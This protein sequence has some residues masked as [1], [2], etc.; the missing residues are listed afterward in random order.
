MSMRAA[1]M[2]AA[3]M[4]AAGPAP[5]ARAADGPVDL[6][7]IEAI[8]IPAEPN[9][10][11]TRAAETLREELGR[12]Y[13]LKLRVVRAAPAKGAS[14]ILV[15]R[16]AVRAGLIPA[17]ALEPLKP[18]GFVVKARRGRIALAGADRQGN[19]YAAWTLLRRAGLRIYPWHYGPHA[20]RISVAEPLPAG[21]LPAFEIAEKPFYH[22]RD[23]AGHLDRGRWGMSRR[24]LVLGDPTQ[25]ANRDLFGRDRKS[26]YT[27]FKL[28]DSDYVGWCHTA[29]Y[30]VPRD[31]YYAA[32]PEYFAIHRQK[33]IGPQGFGRMAVCMTHPDVRRI[34]A[35]RAVQWMDIQSDRRFFLVNQ[36]DRALCQCPRCRAAD[37]LPG[38]LT[39]RMLDW[40]NHVADACR[41]KHPEKVV[42]T[43][44]YM[45]TVKP[46][47][48]VRPAPNVAVMYCPWFWDSRA[49]SEVSLAGPLNVTAMKELMGW[50]MTCPGQVAIY[51]Y[52]T[53]C[54][55]GTAERIRLYARHGIRIAHFNAGRG[56]RLH[57]LAARLMWDPF[58]D[59]EA[60]E[61][62]F[63]RATHGPAAGPMRDYY[64]LRRRTVRRCS[65]HA[66]DIVAPR[67]NNPAA[68]P[69]A[70]FDEARRLLGR[71]AEIAHKAAP[72]VR[73]RILTEVLEE[74]HPILLATHPTRGGEALRLPAGAWK[75]DLVA[76]LRACRQCL[77]D[78][79]RLKLRYLPRRLKADFARRMRALGVSV[80]A[81]AGDRDANARAVIDDLLK[82]IDRAV[83]DS[84]GKP[85]PPARPRTVTVRFDGDAEPG[86]WLAD[87]TEAELVRPPRVATVALPGGEKLTG[88]RFPAA[89]T[90]LPTRKR[91]NIE[92][93]T[94]RF[95]A[96]R[97]L[98]EPIDLTG[99]H[100]VL[101]H[102]H[103][104]ADVPA[105]IYL[106]EGRTD[107]R[108]HAG[109]QIVRVDL[110][111]F[112]KR[113]GRKWDKLRRLAIDLWPQ[114]NFYPHAEVADADLTVVGLTATNRMPDV[115]A[116]PHRGKAAW[117]SAFRPNL[118]F[119][120][121]V[122]EA[123]A[124]R[125]RRS[126]QKHY[127]PEW[128]SRHWR[129]RFR[130]F[131]EHRTLT[132]IYAIV[133]GA[134]PAERRAARAVQ[135]WLAH[136]AGAKLPI[137]PPA[138]SI[139][140]RT[141]NVVLLGGAA[142]AA[143]RITR[144][145]LDYVGEKGVAIN[146]TDGRIA[147]AGPDPAATAAATARY[148]RD[149]GVTFPAPDEPA[150]PPLFRGMLHELY[151]LERPLEGGAA[152]G[153]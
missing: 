58:Q 28:K 104:G 145:E 42:V 95:F 7:G 53:D 153:R 40:V 111:A 48:K 17:G 50:C 89:L 147:L 120:L 98:A 24:E 121:P 94:G 37:P 109:E 134:D 72:E 139:G 22:Y 8:C 25:A 141:S 54:A 144:R 137:G 103:A 131:T 1:T 105:T 92:V 74:T 80:P 3:A 26:G 15:G 114:D 133:A 81:D 107:L 19:I 61:D 64:R 135:D 52:P 101:I 130:S 127:W 16:A 76:H 32:H 148:M 6:K 31:L 85:A 136:V 146:A 97:E 68:A 44:A 110:R 102:L 51:D 142:G 151:T 77:A 113:G 79:E 125:M 112:E 20:D 115:K 39:D 124:R 138:L 108:L 27:K 2:L 10:G 21:R 96:Q 56:S 119:D 132:P 59:V 55:R 93:H 5:A 23:L 43:T 49:S 73:T 126:K 33:R 100:S 67:M 63:L 66:R 84:V 41:R 45:E 36:A 90:R 106:N 117:L 11:E 143:G 14:A 65:A 150:A 46:P 149:H 88:L 35:E 128:V 129:A 70:F 122:S 12:L 118:K 87:S 60:L 83:A 47:A 9:A 4:A 123:W 71:A 99:L 18:D 62:E 69:P 29:G 57:W 38:V 86:K 78:A 34:S 82:R 13:G 91:G 152:R 75:A 140:P 30:L 116:L